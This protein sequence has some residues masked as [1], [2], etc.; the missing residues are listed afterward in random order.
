MT[1]FEMMQLNATLGERSPER[2]TRALSA[3]LVSYNLLLAGIW[4]SLSARWSAAPWLAIG[5]VAA[6]VAALIAARRQR[7]SSQRLSIVDLLPLLLLAA[8]WAELRPLFPLLHTVTLD[9]RIV[10][11]EK[12]VLGFNVHAV[13]WHVMPWLRGTMELLYFGYF[14][15]QIAILSY[16]ALRMPAAAFRELLL[17]GVV[18][19]LVCDSIYLAVP[20]LG[21]RAVQASLEAN[22]AGHAGGVFQLFNDALR[23]F[24]DSPGTAFPSSHVAG[25]LTVAIAARAT[26]NRTFGNVM[27]ALGI[28]VSAATVYTQNHYLLDAIGGAALAI[29]LQYALLPVLL[30][31]TRAQPA[32]E[33]ATVR[34]MENLPEH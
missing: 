22:A 32:V 18:T 3:L 4:I 33:A 1:P 24:G 7:E 8:F 21:P 6:A 27:T 9:S 12:S 5:H 17:R 28:G 31:A 30:G 2:A 14:P 15:G 11:L 29:T 19:Y 26:G 16:V 13:W 34:P 23:S 10:A 20:T 25:I